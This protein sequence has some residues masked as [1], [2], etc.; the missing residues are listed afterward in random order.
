MN[1]LRT[2]HQIIDD[3]G[4]DTLVLINIS[5]A[6][7][8]ILPLFLAVF[9]FLFVY[10]IKG[11]KVKGIVVAITITQAIIFG[12]IGIIELQNFAGTITH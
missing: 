9:N 4:E 8:I 1:F 2:V 11:D 6:S 5:L 10:F 7:S 12:L 3:M